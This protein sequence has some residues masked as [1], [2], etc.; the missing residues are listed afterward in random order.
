VLVIFFEK[1]DLDRFVRGIDKGSEDREVILAAD[2]RAYEKQF[3][4]L[5]LIPLLP[6]F[7][8]IKGKLILLK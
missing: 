7:V 1:T 4:S 5:F 2:D 3:N 8:R 6:F